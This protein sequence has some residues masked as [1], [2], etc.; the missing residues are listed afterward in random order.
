MPLRGL[1]DFTSGGGTRFIAQLTLYHESLGVAIAQA[2]YDTGEDEE[3]AVFQKLL[4]ELDLAGLPIQADPLHASMH[5][6]VIATSVS[7]W[8]LVHASNSL[9]RACLLNYQPPRLAPTAYPPSLNLC[10]QSLPAK[11]TVATG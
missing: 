5:I 8:T 7:S 2:C 4:D 9:W 6:P 11:P 3:L 10:P 1:I